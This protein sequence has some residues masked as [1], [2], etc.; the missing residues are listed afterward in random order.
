MVISKGWAEVV[1]WVCSFSYVRYG[2]SGDLLYT[3]VSIVNRVWVSL[4][5]KSKSALD[6]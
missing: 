3:L 1:P 4:M 6:F 5:Q 2:G